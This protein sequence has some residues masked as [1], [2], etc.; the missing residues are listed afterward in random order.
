MSGR[1]ES[2]LDALTLAN[3]I[4]DVDVIIVGRGGG[5]IEDLWAFNDEKLARAIA[6]SPVPVVSAVG[7]EVDFTI[8]DFVADLRAPTPSA[9]AELVVKSATEIMDKIG[10]L[11]SRLLQSISHKLKHCRNSLGQYEKLLVDPKRRL[12]DLS[13]KCDELS[14][15]MDLAIKN[16]FQKLKF[17][18]QILEGKL[19]SP[20]EAI[21]NRRLALK[22][23]KEKLAAQMSSFLDLRQGEFKRFA[24]LLDSLSPA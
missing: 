22:A 17:E 16:R 3:K 19:I 6:A 10:H 12:Q 24:S 13:Q 14:Q 9:A 15:R 20:Q 5:S 18:L 1:P 11:N 4:P 8:A 21:N 7:H 23:L 2:I